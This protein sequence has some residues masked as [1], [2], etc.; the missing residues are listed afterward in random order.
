LWLLRA[1]QLGLVASLSR[2]GGNVT[3]A[4]Q[5]IVEVGPKPLELAHELAPTATLVALLVN[6]NNPS[7]ENSLVAA[8]HSLKQKRVLP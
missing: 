1:V 4:T 3:G 7:A 5:L 6:P 8:L 2:P